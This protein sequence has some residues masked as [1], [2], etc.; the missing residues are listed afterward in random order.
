MAACDAGPSHHQR[1]VIVDGV[2]LVVLVGPDAAAPMV[3]RHDEHGLVGPPGERAHGGIHLRGGCEVRIRHPSVGVTGP[4]AIGQVEK[5]QPLFRLREQPVRRPRGVARAGA[6]G[7]EPA[8]A[9]GGRER[10]GDGQ[11][12]GTELARHDVGRDA[13]P[14]QL[15]GHRPQRAQTGQEGQPGLGEAVGLGRDAGGE[16]G[17][18]G[19]CGA[20]ADR[21]GLAGE[22]EGAAQR[23]ERRHDAGSDRI[24]PQPVGQDD[25]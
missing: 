16:R 25:H 23:I 10:P 19:H 21:A 22:S 3:R 9:G 17:K 2:G 7:H 18:G 11:G 4:I 8:D 13:G 24:G 6:L 12:G 15:P 14:S 5:Q 1:D 20:G